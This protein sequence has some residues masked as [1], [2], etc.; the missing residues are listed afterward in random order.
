MPSILTSTK[1]PAH[2]HFVCTKLPNKIIEPLGIIYQYLFLK[3]SEY[4]FIGWPK[5]FY[6][7]IST[8]TIYTHNSL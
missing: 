3:L 1:S 6:S 8:F 2:N 4:A 5:I 7:T